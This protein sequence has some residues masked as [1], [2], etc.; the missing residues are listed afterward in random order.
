[1]IVKN[2]LVGLPEGENVLDAQWKLCGLVESL[3][4]DVNEDFSTPDHARFIGIFEAHTIILYP[5]VAPS[6]ALWFT[7][8]HLYG[9]MTQLLNK[10]PRV[11]RANSLVLQTGKTLLPE[12]AQVI[13]DHEREAAEIGRAL[14]AKV[15]PDLASEMDLAY[16]RFFHADFR[17]LLNVIETGERGPA[18]FERYWRHEPTPRELIAADSRELLNMKDV[19]I[20][21]DRIIVV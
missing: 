6:F 14:I 21:S 10:T 18:V 13:Y 17:Y 8:A 11:D 1:M 15:E 20:T 4:V 19:P 9:H 12:D 3:G 5:R 16:A 2:N 7:V